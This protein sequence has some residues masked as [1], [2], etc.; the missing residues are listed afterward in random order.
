MRE[1]RVARERRAAV[2]DEVA[3]QLEL[4]RGQIRRLAG[5]RHLGAPHIDDDLA[6]AIDVAAR[7]RRRPTAPQQRLESGHQLDRLERL[8]QIVVG[9]ELQ[10][11]DLVD[12]LPPRREHQDWR[13]DAALA[14]R[15]ADVEAVHSRQHHVEHDQVVAAAL[16]AREAGFPVAGRLDA[17]ALAAEPIRERE[18]KPRFVLDEEH[19]RRHAHGA[20]SALPRRTTVT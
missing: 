6:E 5:A 10:A 8:R 7:L 14:Y 20:M 3:Q 12:D 9:A 1:Q 18:P 16:R 19:A 11:D 2:L 15:A 17:V 4:P 13:G